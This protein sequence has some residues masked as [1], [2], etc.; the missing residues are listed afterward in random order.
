VADSVLWEGCSVAADARVEGALLGP[1]VS[2]GASARVAP[3][4]VL[5]EASRL[6]DFSRTS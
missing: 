5:G 4:A 1:S 3:G 6:S 2:V